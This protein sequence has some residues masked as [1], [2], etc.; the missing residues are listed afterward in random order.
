M[1]DSDRQPSGCSSPADPCGEG[2]KGDLEL[3]PMASTEEEPCCGPVIPQV[4][5][6]Y[7]RPGYALFGF[8]DTFIETPAGRVPSVKTRLTGK[9]HLGSASVR[10]GA[11]RSSYRIAPGIYAVGTPGAGDPVLVTA[12]YKLTFDTLRKHLPGRNAWIL[13]L[14]TYGVNVW[15][16]AG[17]GSFSTQEV[18]RRVR[19]TGIDKVVTHRRLVLPQLAATGVSAERVRQGCGFKVTWGPI[20]AQ[21]LGQFLDNKMK[22]AP[23][24]RRVTFTTVE[25]I[26][27]I[28]VEFSHIP[29]PALWTLAAIF[30]LSGFGP[31]LFSF[32]SAW[33]RG[34]MMASACGMAILAGNVAVP[35]LLPWLPGRAFAV[36]GLLT[37][38]G[39]GLLVL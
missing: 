4:S 36:K 12:N 7:E 29:K 25:R 24:M 13:V 39:A 34:W 23:A 15:C 30:V 32:G 28:P 26:V 33:V 27:L 11:D 22:A 16:A 6:S 19:A 8:V 31:G 38:V 17:K 10:L 37:G 21:D 5:P 2:L 20:R 35:A 3:L 1:T 18:V 9:D 14:E